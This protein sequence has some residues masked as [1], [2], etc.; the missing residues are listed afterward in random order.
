MS[1]KAGAAAAGWLGASLGAAGLSGL[2]GFQGLD[3]HRSGEGLAVVV[4][5]SEDSSLAKGVLVEDEGI[6]TAL[7]GV[8][9]G[10]R[11]LLE[12]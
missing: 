4:S 3:G 7:S 6:S 8:Q 5:S 12:A 9:P 1:L 10:G 2:K 11:R